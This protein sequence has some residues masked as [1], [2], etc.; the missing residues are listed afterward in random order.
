MSDVCLTAKEKEI[1]NLLVDAWDKYLLLETKE[2]NINDFFS[3]INNCQRLI[4]LRVARRA[5]PDFWS[6]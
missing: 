4:G 1:L 3:S 5:D 6:K 2:S